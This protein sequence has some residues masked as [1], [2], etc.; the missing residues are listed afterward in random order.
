[1]DGRL[2]GWMI[3]VHCFIECDEPSSHFQMSSLSINQ[4]QH[5]MKCVEVDTGRNLNIRG[6]ILCILKIV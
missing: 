2:D 1:M 5:G 6:E 3:V 4:Q